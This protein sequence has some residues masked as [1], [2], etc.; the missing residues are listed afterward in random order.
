MIYLSGKDVDFMEKKRTSKARKV[1]NIVLAI[2]LIIFLAAAGLIA[3]LS[4]TE[5]KP[6]DV[7][8]LTTGGTS[9]SSIGVGDQLSVLTWNIGYGAL[10]DNADFFMDGGEMVKSATE[11][12]VKENMAGITG[13]VTKLDPDVS[14]FQEVDSDSTRSYHID[15]TAILGNLSPSDTES[16]ALYYSVAFVPYPIPPI[17]E[18]HTNLQTLSRFPVSKAQRIQL[19]ISFSWPVRTANLKRCL[20]V[21]RVPLDNSDRELVLVN[22]HLEAYDSGEGKIAQTRQLLDVL[23]KEIK[24]GNYVIAAG[25]FNQTFS[26][27]NLSAY[28][29]REGMWTPGIIDVEDFAPNFELLMDNTTPTCRSLDQPLAGA[30]EST[31]QYYMIDGFI[32]SKNV[33]VQSVETQDFGFKN[34]DH[35]PV[36]LRATLNE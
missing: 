25:D 8:N 26:N 22:L 19:P 21:S 18:V 2:L 36:L 1:L 7:E 32:V 3:W 17:G 13:A 34:S 27:T 24:K 10:G 9:K 5:Y 31:F 35:N 11:D 15:E 33:E 16:E 6:K 12:R 23:E 14:F 4:I 30:D 29:I 28:P 20:M